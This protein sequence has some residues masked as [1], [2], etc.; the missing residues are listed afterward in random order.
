MRKRT[1]FT[2]ET[3]KKVTS[4]DNYLTALKAIAENC[5]FDDKNRRLRDRIVMGI[6]DIRVRERILREADPD[7][8]KEKIIRS[9]EMAK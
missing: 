2:Q 7:L 1:D 3:K 8:T 4:I 9:T 5:Q 6:R